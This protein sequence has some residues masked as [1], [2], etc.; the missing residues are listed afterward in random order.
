MI[1]RCSPFRKMILVA[2]WKT[3]WVGSGEKEERK[4]YLKYLPKNISERLVVSE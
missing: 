4:V 3:D 2:L 1:T